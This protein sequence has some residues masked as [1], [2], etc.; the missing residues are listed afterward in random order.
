MLAL[1]DIC[2]NLVQSK[3]VFAT[4]SDKVGQCCSSQSCIILQKKELI[5]H[6]DSNI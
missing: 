2:K 3:K 4:Y 1:F 5:D 6:G